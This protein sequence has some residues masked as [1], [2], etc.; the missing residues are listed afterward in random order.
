MRAGAAAAE[1]EAATAGGSTRS[2]GTILRASGRETRAATRGTT[3]VE[4]EEKEESEEGREE[5]REE[6]E[7]GPGVLLQLSPVECLVCAGGANAS[8]A[9]SSHT[10][11][12]RWTAVCSATPTQAGP[13]R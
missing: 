1:Y 3:G 5:R 6:E 7:E 10:E 2:M 4:E 13:S 11:S 9:A 8:V 12:H